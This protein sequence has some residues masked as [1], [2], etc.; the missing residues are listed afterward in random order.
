MSTFLIG[1]SVASLMVKPDI[2]HTVEDYLRSVYRLESRE[3]KASNA[4]LARELNITAAAVTD[5]LRRLADQGL[6]T[7]TKYQGSSLTEAG[8]EIA[9]NVTRR[10][11]LWEVFLIQHLGFG[12][13]EVHDIADE[14]EHISS[15]TLID[16]LDEFL[17]FPKY[18]PHGDPIPTKEGIVAPDTLVPLS[19]LEVG[20]TGIVGRV[21]DEYPELLRYASSLGL[22]IRAKIKVI[23]KIAFDSSIRIITDTKESVVS[24]KLANSVFVERIPS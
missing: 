8:R 1:G 2:N 9:T 5:M 19:T 21:S 22:S 4:S 20:D 10:H 3:G 11:R 24:E 16:R 23:E 14:L 7:Y 17:G 15:E 12:W 13:D 6:L 18:D